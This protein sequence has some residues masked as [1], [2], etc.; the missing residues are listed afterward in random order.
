MNISDNIL[1]NNE[2]LGRI[3]SLIGLS[4]TGCRCIIKNKTNEIGYCR[5]KT[6]NKF[7]RV[8][9]KSVETSTNKT[10]TY[11]RE[12]LVKYQIQSLEQAIDRA[13]VE[14]V[15]QPQNEIIVP[16]VQ[17]K[18]LIKLA[19]DKEGIHNK[20]VNKEAN[21]IWEVLKYIEV[22]PK[23]KTCG[24]V[25]VA[26]S[27]SRRAEIQLVDKYY[28][29]FKNPA[30]QDYHLKY[31]IVLDHLWAFISSHKNRNDLIQRLSEELEDSVETCIIGNITRLCLTCEGFL[32]DDAHDKISQIMSEMKKT[33]NEE[34]IDIRKIVDVDDRIA[35]AI[36]VLEKNKVPQ[37][38]WVNWLEYI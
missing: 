4:I 21:A 17:D 3:N 9:E 25:I 32:D 38:D 18:Q 36:G 33:L 24:E 27:I 11:I 28:F 13:I 22:P 6:T 37:V 12:E 23:Q 16:P 31:D 29:S 20:A 7:C 26:C 15:Q 35:A 19:K 10:L 30:A 2:E 14:A 8:H 5:I 34:F 1:D